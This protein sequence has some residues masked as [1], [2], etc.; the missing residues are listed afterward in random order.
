MK[1]EIAASENSSKGASNLLGID[2]LV[3][4]WTINVRNEEYHRK[5]N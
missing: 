5:S 4:K 1:R 2:Y 3:R